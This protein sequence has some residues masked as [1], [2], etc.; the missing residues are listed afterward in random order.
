MDEPFGTTKGYAPMALASARPAGPPPTI[1][2][3]RSSCPEFVLSEKYL[4]NTWE[5]LGLLQGLHSALRIFELAPRIA[6]TTNGERGPE[7]NNYP[8]NPETCPL[9]T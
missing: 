3:S 5:A 6:V 7:N 4:P 1:T 9:P 2:T 8:E